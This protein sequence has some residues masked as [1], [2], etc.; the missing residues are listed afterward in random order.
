MTGCRKSSRWEGNDCKP[1]Q[2]TLRHGV[3]GRLCLSFVDA[4]RGPA[5]RGYGPKLG[6]D[7]GAG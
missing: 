1:S 6:Y 3:A 5:L 2:V 7:Y 4:G